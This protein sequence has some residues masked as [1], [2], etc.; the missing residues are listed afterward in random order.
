MYTQLLVNQYHD[1]NDLPQQNKEQALAQ[2]K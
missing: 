2:Y 1:M